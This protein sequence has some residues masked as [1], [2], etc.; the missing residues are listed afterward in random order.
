MKALVIINVGKDESM[1]IALEMKEY[2][3]DLS[4]ETDFINFDGFSDNFTISNYDFAITLGGD[5]TVLYAAR[6][7]V[8]NNIP[9]FPVNL[10]QFGFIATVQPEDWKKE[11]LN[12]LHNDVVKTQRLMLKAEVLRNKKSVYSSFGLNEIVICATRA[13]SAISLDV[14]YNFVPLCKLISDGV[15]VSTPTGST[16]Y[17]AAAG[18]PI[19]DSEMEACVLTPVNPFSLSSRPLVLN[20]N[21]KIQIKVCKSTPKPFLMKA[22]NMIRRGHSS[23]VFVGDSTIRKSLIRSGVSEEDAR[24]CNVTGCYEYSPPLQ[25]IPDSAH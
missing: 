25:K 24:D 22:L 19:I 17:S 15:I 10:G 4:V 23:I 21:G 3:N 14:E 6:N 11:L 16:A 1:K 9:I 2:L 20:P 12:F 5:G 13:A 8:E 18:G 7:C